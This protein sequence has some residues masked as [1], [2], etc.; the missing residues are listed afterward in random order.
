MGCSKNTL[1]HYLMLCMSFPIANF[2]MK[3]HSSYYSKSEVGTCINWIC[4][5]EP[6]T[7]F[8]A[9]RFYLMMRNKHIFKVTLLFLP[10][11]HNMMVQLTMERHEVNPD[12]QRVPRSMIFLLWSLKS[13]DANGC[14]VSAKLTHLSMLH[15]LFEERAK[16]ISYLEKWSRLFLKQPKYLSIL[17]QPP[18]TLWLS[19]LI[20][21]LLLD[22]NWFLATVLLIRQESGKHVKGT[23]LPAIFKPKKSQRRI[24][25]P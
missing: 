10:E 22:Q 9:F 5:R 13:S 19:N 18:I 4:K 23:T 16:E 21:L 7:G 12:R 1:F 25:P 11:G 20:Q 3:R 15:Q 17:F 2:C 6:F 14:L 8:F 24:F